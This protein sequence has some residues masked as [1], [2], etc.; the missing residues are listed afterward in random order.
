M[1]VNPVKS[2]M[3]KYQYKRFANPIHFKNCFP[4]EETLLS[5]DSFV[6]ES[7]LKYLKNKRRVLNNASFRKLLGTVEQRFHQI[8]PKP[9]H[10]DLSL[11]SPWLSKKRPM[12]VK[13]CRNRPHEGKIYIGATVTHSS[14]DD[15]V[16]VQEA[17]ED[18]IGYMPPIFAAKATV[19][20]PPICEGEVWTVGWVQTLTKSS[21]IKYCDNNFT[22]VIFF[23]LLKV[24]FI[25]SVRK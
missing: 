16:A 9:K 22:L 19:A 18:L 14:D 12:S 21:M 2:R 10:Y 23:I 13:N 7:S 3:P 8:I 15:F 17:E 1:R 6:D 5:L 4:H 20:F 11:C 25:Y 24:L